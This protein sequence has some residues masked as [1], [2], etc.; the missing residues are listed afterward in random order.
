EGED[1]FLTMLPPD[2][3]EELRDHQTRGWGQINSLL[4]PTF[5]SCSSELQS[6]LGEGSGCRYGTAVDFDV[7]VHD[8]VDVRIDEH[9]ADIAAQVREHIG[10]QML[11]PDPLNELGGGDLP[12]RVS[13]RDDVDAAFNHL[14]GWMSPG[15]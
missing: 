3:R 12:A 15:W 9:M 13:T 4:F 1:L 11:T 2:I 8:D 10:G 6:I 14:T 7:G 5:A